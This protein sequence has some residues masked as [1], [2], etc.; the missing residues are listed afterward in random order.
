VIVA[1]YLKKAKEK[2]NLEKKRKKKEKMLTQAR[3]NIQ[4]AALTKLAQESKRIQR[5]SRIFN[6]YKQF[7]QAM[8]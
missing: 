3:K 1:Y 6:I 4:Q 2:V 8:I 7:N 5:N